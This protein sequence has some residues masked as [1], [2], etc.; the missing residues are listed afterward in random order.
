MYL[1]LL[2]YIWNWFGKFFCLTHF[3]E[4]LSTVSESTGEHIQCKESLKTWDPYSAFQPLLEKGERVP[5]LDERIQASSAI[6]YLWVSF[7]CHLIC[8]SA[9]QKLPDFS[10]LCYDQCIKWFSWVL[11]VSKG[12]VEISQGTVLESLYFLSLVLLVCLSYYLLFLSEAGSS[13]KFCTEVT[14]TGAEILVMEMERWK[15]A[16]KNWRRRGTQAVGLSGHFVFQKT[17]LLDPVGTLTIFQEVSLKEHG[18]PRREMLLWEH[19]EVREQGQGGCKKCTW[20]NLGEVWK[21]RMGLVQGR[22]FE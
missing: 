13:S 11:D 1:K 17:F 4:Y 16:Q 3:G 6:K 10:G 14:A 15:E 22:K 18:C 12:T 19:M 8:S 2:Y 20:P 21:V 5:H 7:S 9:K